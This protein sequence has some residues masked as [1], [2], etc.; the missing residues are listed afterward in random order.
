[1]RSSGWSVEGH[2][3]CRLAYRGWYPAE[4]APVPLHEYALQYL[5]E[6]PDTI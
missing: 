5:I 1:M 6:L 4:S 3:H 2:R